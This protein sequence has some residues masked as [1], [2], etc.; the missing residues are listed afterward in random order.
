MTSIK[1]Q[2]KEYQPQQIKNISEVEVVPVD[3]EVV[4]NDFTD[5]EGKPFTVK[6]VNIDG[7]DYRVPISVLKSLKAILEEKKDLKTF[8][9]VKTGEGMNTSYTVIPLG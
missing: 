4:D 7:E 8:K 2:A 5:S 1:E 3:L 9:V 6:V